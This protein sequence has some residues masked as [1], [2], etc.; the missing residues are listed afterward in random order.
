MATSATTNATSTSAITTPRVSH[1]FHRGDPLDIP[2]ID[3]HLLTQILLPRVV[4]AIRYKF[5]QVHLDWTT[6]SGSN[7]HH[8]GEALIGG[9]YNSLLWKRILEGILRTCLILGSCRRIISYSARRR[10]L[11]SIGGGKSNNNDGNPRAINR[12]VYLATPG[13][14]S[15]G[16]SVRSTDRSD[17]GGGIIQQ[18]G[19]VM[20]LILATVIVPSCYEELRIRRERQLD[21]RDQRLRMEE[22]RRELRSSMLNS[23]SVTSSTAYPAH[24]T[25][26]DQNVTRRQQESTSIERQRHQ[27]HVQLLLN[28]RSRER[29]SLVSSLIVDA[30]LGMGEVLCPP[31]Q[32]F[33][34]VMYLWGMSS[35]PDL[36]M[37]VAGW[38]YCRDPSS[39]AFISFSDGGDNNNNMI[40]YDNY[41]DVVE[42]QQPHRR[43]FHQRHAN[44]QY[45]YRRLL[46]E[47]AL[48]A[49]SMI[50]PPRA[51]NAGSTG[52]AV[53]NA[54]VTVDTPHRANRTIN[55]RHED[56]WRRPITRGSVEEGG[57]EH[58][59]RNSEVRSR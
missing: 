34:Y 20:M 13:M 1:S 16:T 3:Q 4:S 45:G 39:S 26:G 59:S 35:T 41:G 14:Q 8:Q 38:E 5:P 50:L 22:I 46:V 42:H 7:G 10:R 17:G 32:L 57:E 29:K 33:N 53:G 19:K 51:H 9:N 43:S 31:L 56:E 52:G 12:E 58:N 36:G 49:A 25:A 27:Q 47:E 40:S 23:A 11:N 55:E 44:F 30:I 37:R 21:E 18:Y 6:G 54:V 24:D 28:Q 2:L 48:R 15:C